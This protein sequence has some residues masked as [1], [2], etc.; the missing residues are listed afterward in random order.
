VKIRDRQAR[1]MARIKLGY[2]MIEA[3]CVTLLGKLETGEV[4]LT[5]EEIALHLGSRVSLERTDEGTLVA[6]IVPASQVPD[7]ASG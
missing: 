1:D 4:T 3:V 7:G 2:E 6:R 5:K